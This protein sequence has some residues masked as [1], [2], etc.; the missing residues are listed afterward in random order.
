MPATLQ[1]KLKQLRTKKGYSLDELA[2]LSGSSKSYLWELENRPERKPSAE[3]LM[4]SP[5]GDSGSGM[6]TGS[7]ASAAGTSDPLSGQT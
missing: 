1:E 7:V 4:A 6:R 2:K 5:C 3:K